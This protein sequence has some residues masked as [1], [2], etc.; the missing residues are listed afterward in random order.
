MKIGGL[1]MNGREIKKDL[2]AIATFLLSFFLIYF[3][4]TKGKYFYGSTLD[5]QQQHYLIPEYFRNLFYQTKDIF[6]NFAPHLGSGQNIYYFSY[7]GLMSPLILLSYFLPFL[8]M[9]DYIQLLGVLIP[10]ISTT[11]FY[12]YLKKHTTYPIAFLTSFLFL[13]ASPI[14]FHSHRHLMFISY[15]PFYMLALFGI[16]AFFEKKKS[17][18]FLVSLFLIIMTSYYYSVGSFLALFCYGIYYGVKRKVDKKRYIQFC[19]LFFIAILSSAILLLPTLYTLMSGR[20]VGK[21][22][23]ISTLFRPKRSLRFLLYETYALGT[24]VLSF[25]SILHLFFTKKKENILAAVFLTCISIFPLVNYLLNGTLYIDAKTLIPFLPVVLLTVSVFL[26]DLFS[27]RI[28][29]KE[30]IF[31][32]LI[33]FL[34]TNSKL[35]A[36]DLGMMAIFFVFYF[37]TKKEIPTL[38]LLGIFPFLLCIKVNL[39]DELEKKSLIQNENYSHMEEALDFIASKEENIYRIHNAM[40]P[41]LTM[42]KIQNKHHYATTLYSSSFNKTYNDLYFEKIG[43]PIPYRNKSM[44]PAS[45]NPLSQILMGEKYIVTTSPSIYDAKRIYEKGKVKV[46]EREHVLPIGYA[47]SHTIS[48]EG[49]NY[50]SLAVAYLKGIV[51]EEEVETFSLQ[52]EELQVEGVQK[53]NVEIEKEQDSYKVSARKNAS[54]Q[55]DLKEH[56]QGKILFL[57]F[58]NNQNVK[59]GEKELEIAIN[60][61]KNKLSCPTWKYYNHNEVFDYVIEN[62]KKLTISFGEGKY[63]LSNVE[64]YSISYEEL[65][66]FIEDIDPF[67]FDK[68]HTVGDNMVGDITAS[69]DG[70]FLLSIPYDR[71]FK[72]KVDGEKINIEEIN[73]AYIGFKIKKGR[74]HIEIKYEAPYKKMGIFLSSI[75]I[76]MMIVI[77]VVEKR[78]RR[79]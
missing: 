43:N 12:F 20:G 31:I 4:I 45:N 38:L 17:T 27:K 5:W 9:I 40:F 64:I 51:Q 15:M 73:D 69:Q 8:K 18:L 53:Q 48:K 19:I 79:V 37:L 1:T 42:N 16:D 29:R 65:Y 61:M 63:D 39:K 52:T 75:G 13:C 58:K 56:Y 62:P 78:K 7:Y 54:I 35:V 33:I 10:T 11:L 14:I 59:C 77:I 21:T 57:R 28:K 23:E 74:H 25:I 26:E 32:F 22:L 24:T 3:L 36:L 2:L 72:A 71:G 50:P 30:L 6:P 34:F 44:T 67:L 49:L 66:S 46:F 68:E 55:L 41:S 70:Y 76:C 47:T 60:G